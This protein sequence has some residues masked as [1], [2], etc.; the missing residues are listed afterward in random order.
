MQRL[1]VENIVA[2]G[3]IAHHEQFSS[4]ATMFS[5]VVCFRGVRKRL[6]IKFVSYDF[7]TIYEQ[8][9]EK[10]QYYIF[11]LLN[12]VEKVVAKGKIAYNEHFL[13]LILC[14]QRRLLQMYQN[15]SIFG[16]WTKRNFT[17]RPL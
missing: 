15:V 2:K 7:E 4:F 3:E 9:H 17:V 5:K 11:Y 16:K 13:L 8:K 10:C 14:F 6:N 12:L 1:K